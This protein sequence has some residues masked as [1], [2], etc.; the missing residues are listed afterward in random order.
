M[1]HLVSIDLLELRAH[2]VAL[3]ADGLREVLAIPRVQRRVAG[4]ERAQRHERAE[5][6]RVVVLPVLDDLERVRRDL[7]LRRGEDRDDRRRHLS[8]STSI[9]KADAA[10]ERQ[11]SLGR[12]FGD[13]AGTKDEGE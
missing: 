2:A 8:R 4:A 13:K 3:H 12:G 1:C 6:L 7:A 11:S 9:G 10:C 5:L